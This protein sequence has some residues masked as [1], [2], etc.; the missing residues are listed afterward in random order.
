MKVQ[1]DTLSEN[2]NPNFCVSLRPWSG[3]GISYSLGKRGGESA[4]WFEVHFR[5]F[6]FKSTVNIEGV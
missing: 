3:V 1:R 2:R 6:Y 5:D 4:A